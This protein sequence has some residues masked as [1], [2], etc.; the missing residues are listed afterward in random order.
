MNV[1][2]GAIDDTL[3]SL[4]EEK[5][6]RS[7]MRIDG[8]TLE[9]D[10]AIA[11][12]INQIEE[13]LREESDMFDASGVNLEEIDGNLGEVS[14]PKAS[15]TNL[16]DLSERQPEDDIAIASAIHEVESEL[17]QENSS[18]S[19]LTLPVL[20]ITIAVM[21]AGILILQAFK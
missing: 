12:A 3:R 20:V 2:I 17:K 19:I 5:R 10:V 7:P 14:T 8:I 21:V 18:F 6:A 13:E 1:D 9:D 15:T 4:S 11:T 16:K